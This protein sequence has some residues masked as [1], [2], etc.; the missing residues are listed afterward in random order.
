[1]AALEEALGFQVGIPDKSGLVL[2]LLYQSEA[3]LALKWQDAAVA[4]LILAENLS[5]RI[6]D[7]ALRHEV[8][9]RI[10]LVTAQIGEKVFLALKERLAGQAETVRHRAMSKITGK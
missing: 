4:W 10:R 8:D 9:Q 1:L 5:S 3:F 6:E 2:N 7:S